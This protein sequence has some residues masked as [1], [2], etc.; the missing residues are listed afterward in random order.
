M[1][2]K[3]WMIWKMVLLFKWKSSV[4]KDQQQALALNGNTISSKESRLTKGDISPPAADSSVI[5]TLTGDT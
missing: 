1:R 2:M 4:P 5:S 3:S